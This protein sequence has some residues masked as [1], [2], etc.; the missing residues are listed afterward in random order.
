MP[1]VKKR[2]AIKSPKSPKPSG[3]LSR[4]IHEKL[5]GKKS[6][7]FVFGGISL[8]SLLVIFAMS[9]SGTN[10]FSTLSGHI[11]RVE[12]EGLI[13]HD[14]AQLELFQQLEND[15]SVK[16]VIL[17]VNSPGGSAAASEAMYEAIRA[18]AKKKPTVATVDVMAASGGYIVALGAD[19]IIARHNS[20][21]GSIG[22]LLEWVEL[23]KMLENLGVTPYVVRSSKFKGD[24]SLY[25]APSKESLRY[26]QLGVNDA[27]KWFENLVKTRRKIKSKDMK[28]VVGGHVYVGSRALKYN[29]IDALGGEVQAVKWLEKKRKVPKNLEVILWQVPDSDEGLWSFLSGS[30]V[31]FTARMLQGFLKD[32]PTPGPKLMSVWRG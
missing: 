29:L 24:P 27:N 20:L 25:R 30:V 16:G 13:M 5:R 14:R 26:L 3:S 10:V 6:W 23:S 15:E 11:A 19:H 7:Y 32:L 8:F 12:L 17:Q 18:L 21:V 4:K 31:E 9:G 22:V 1:Q 28:K 2:P